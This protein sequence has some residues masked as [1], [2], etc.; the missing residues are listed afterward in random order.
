VNFFY[1]Q[2]S[3]RPIVEE[4]SRDPF[5][6]AKPTNTETLIGTNVLGELL[7]E[8][9]EEL[10]SPHIDKLRVVEPPTLHK[11]LLIEKPIGV[12]EGPKPKPKPEQLTWSFH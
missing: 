3:D 5:W 11:F 9:R 1:L 6:G 4:S 10:K 8:L 2:E 12:I 7:T